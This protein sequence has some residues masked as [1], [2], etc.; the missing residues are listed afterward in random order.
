MAGE[1]LAAAYAQPSLQPPPNL[2]TSHCFSSS[3]SFSSRLAINASDFSSRLCSNGQDFSPA[4]PCLPKAR[5]W[6]VGL[7][8]QG[9]FSCRRTSIRSDAGVAAAVAEKS[10]V[11]E[12]LR[13]L[14][15]H[16]SVVM[17]FGGSSVA[18]AGRMREVADLVLSFPD[19][20]PIVVLSAMG[21]TT[22]NLLQ[23]HNIVAFTHISVTMCFITFACFL[24]PQ[25]YGMRV[26]LQ[27][28]F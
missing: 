6:A 23:V 2:K 8:G 9:D 27:K 3:S 21:K 13:A 22:N 24:N 4:S 14:S 10:E 15:Q 17:K 5:G 1:A 12:N 11:A 18:S 7:G 20:Q 19:E 26:S 16:F 25:L 28:S